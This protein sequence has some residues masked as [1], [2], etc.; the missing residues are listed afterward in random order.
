MNKKFTILSFA[1][2]FIT[3]STVFGSECQTFYSYKAS[4][5]GSLFLPKPE[6]DLT[7]V[8]AS[9]PL[10]VLNQGQRG[11]CWLY[12]TYEN[13]VNRHINRTGVDPKISLYHLSYF[14]W[15]NRAIEA[16]LDLKSASVEE[17]GSVDLAA[18]I[19]R[20][21][22]VVTEKEWAELGGSTEIQLPEKN[23]LET[24]QINTIVKQSHLEKKLLQ[25]LLA[26][27]LGIGTP[28]PVVKKYY[29]EL[30]SDSDFKILLNNFLVKKKKS[31]KTNQTAFTKVDLDLV[32]KLIKGE[33]NPALDLSGRQINELL[34]KQDQDIVSAVTKLYNIIYFGKETAPKFDTERNIK[35]ASEL[36]PE[37]YGPVILF[38]QSLDRKQKPTITNV[39]KS[40]VEILLSTSD[41]KKIIY[42]LNKVNLPVNLVYDHQSNFVKLVDKNN[43]ENNGVMSISRNK[44]W[45]LFPYFNRRIRQVPSVFYE[46]AGHIVLINGTYLTQK[47]KIAGFNIRNS[48]G[49]EV[50]KKGEFFMDD[51]F[52]GGFGDA[53]PVFFSDIQMPEVANIL[54]PKI[55]QVF[56]GVAATTGSE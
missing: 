19:I 14:H 28:E 7:L 52:F 21:Q 36:F 29:G 16:S 3:Q 11:F 32:E 43:P 40:S 9:T 38:I 49:I 47:N 34:K 31:L 55:M 1:I 10:P 24:P 23:V 17:G 37:L 8:S 42:H 54:G 18:Q 6:R 41:I 13:L 45:P 20:T 2:L 15:L 39:D 30:F 22:G 56:K 50:G 51:S 5:L 4:A 25:E 46:R 27:K 35:L 44:F 48:W 12:A 26:P 33:V 53:V